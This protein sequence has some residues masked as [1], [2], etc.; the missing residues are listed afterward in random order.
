MS[1]ILGRHAALP[2]FRDARSPRRHR[3]HPHCRSRLRE[4]HHA[5]RPAAFQ[6][7]VLAD[8]RKPGR[9]PALLL[10]RHRPGRDLD[11]RGGH[12]H[13]RVRPRC[14]P[15]NR[16]PLP[17]RRAAEPMERSLITRGALAGLVAGALAFIFA[18]IFAEPQVAA[19]IAYESGRDDAQAALDKLAGVPAAARERRGLLPHHPGEHRHRRRRDLL[20]TRA[21][22]D[23]R[24]PGFPGRAASAAV[25][26][27]SGRGLA[28]C[29]SLRRHLPL[30]DH[31]VPGQSAR[32][33]SS[34]H[35]Q[36]AHR[37][38]PDHGR[39]L[40]RRPDRRRLAATPA[41]APVHR[42][43]RH[44]D[45]RRCLHRRDR[46]RYGAAPAAGSPAGQRHRVRPQPTETPLPLTDAKG[47][48]VYPG[49]PADV[50]ARFRVASL[51]TQLILWTAIGLVFGPLAARL[52]AGKPQA[53]TQ[54]A[55]VPA[56]GTR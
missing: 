28:R 44:P 12:S 54:S 9:P 2:G 45:R 29:G 7:G 16:V 53:S 39:L 27:S 25:E 13:P 11:L 37:P 21:R 15:P 47:V 41:S 26:A 33:R 35:D 56:P 40:L 34:R 38:L 22:S 46:R 42:L 36:P 14:P 3:E 17:L 55:Q 48:I 31:Q 5:A 23:V 8:R 4:H 10:H 6:V 52:L 51:G 30:P 19:A 50:L 49:F 24:C 43:E 32:H 1:Q 20:R 18:R